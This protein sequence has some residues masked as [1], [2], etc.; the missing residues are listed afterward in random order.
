MWMKRRKVA[1][2]RGKVQR[3]CVAAGSRNGGAEEPAAPLPASADGQ[4]GQPMGAEG[5]GWRNSGQL[6]PRQFLLLLG[7]EKKKREAG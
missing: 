2:R 5:K 1:G 6:S 3:S 4:T 7:E